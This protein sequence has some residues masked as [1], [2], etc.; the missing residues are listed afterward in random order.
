MYDL[1]SALIAAILFVSMALAIEV[2]YR[3][4]LWQ[5]PATSESSKA[6][7][8]AIQASLLGLLALLLGFN[9][10]LALQRHD[11]RSVAVVEEAN[12]IGTALLRTALLQTDLRV[13]AQQK[14][15]A[16]LEMRLEAAHVD[17]THHAERQALSDHANR[18]H[19]E[20]WRQAARAV[21]REPNA[22]TS[23]LYAQSINELIDAFGRRHSELN[24]HVPEMVLFLLYGSFL[25][26]G[27]IVGY[28]AGV[29]AH[30]PSSVSYV[31]VTLIVMLVFIIIDLDRPRRGLIEVSQE[32]MTELRAGWL[33]QDSPQKR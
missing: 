2:G 23:G 4:G 11:S 1:S 17:L 32:P 27:T 8:N 22:A 30:R 14:L 21:T 24:R 6:H 26:T 5:A 15:A 7:V 28:A 3:F 13:E 31:M 18:L 19:D 29:G 9:F 25:M 33:V 20:L 10:S 12:A 16:Y